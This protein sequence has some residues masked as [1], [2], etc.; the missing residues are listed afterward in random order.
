MNEKRVVDAVASSGGSGVAGGA[1]GLTP[2][3]DGGGATCCA[4]TARHDPNNAARA[5]VRTAP[6]VTPRSAASASNG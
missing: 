1:M 3:I 4:D 2:T 6:I 5:S